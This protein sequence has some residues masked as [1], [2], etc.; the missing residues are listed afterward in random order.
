MAGYGVKNYMRM[1]CRTPW[2]ITSLSYAIPLQAIDITIGAL[3]HILST[4]ADREGHN[5]P[6]HTRLDFF[7][8]RLRRSDLRSAENLHKRPQATAHPRTSLLGHGIT[9]HIRNH[10]LFPLVILETVVR[11]HFTYCS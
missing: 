10:F 8:L 2:P 9:S 4:R 6:R 5:P 11:N 1:V 7:F 3:E